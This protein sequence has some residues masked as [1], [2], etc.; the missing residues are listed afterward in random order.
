M[1]IKG[2]IHSFEPFG[3][4]DG[5]GIRF[6]V[7]MQGCPFKCLFCHNP[8]TWSF[9]SGKFYSVEEV[10]KESKK[11][12]PYLNASGGGITVTGGEPLMQI[13]FLTELFKECK[14]LN[15]HTAIDT[16]GFV[17]TSHEKLETLLSFTDLVLL[18][19]KHMNTK[20][21]EKITGY[22]NKYTLDF[23]EYL[24]NTNIPVWLRYV[25]IPGLTDDFEGLNTLHQFIRSSTNIKNVELLPFHKTGEYKWKTLEKEY[26]LFDTAVPSEADML[27][28]KALVL[29]GTVCDSS[30][31][32]MESAYSDQMNF[33]PSIYS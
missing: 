16:N 27:R 30:L 13:E 11:Y 19:I 26:W 7:F 3:T 17:E 5:P 21:H 14:K 22:T 24:N 18:S 31:K 12:I 9:N 32:H 20:I 15:I 29:S 2:R 33:S 6:V 4:V 23:A 28:A 10:L 8:D 25:I 1:D